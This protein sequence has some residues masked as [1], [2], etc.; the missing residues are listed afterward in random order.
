M[1]WNFASFTAPRRVEYLK[2]LSIPICTSTQEIKGRCQCEI[3][4]FGARKLFNYT[5]ILTPEAG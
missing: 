2:C 4:F 1:L 3:G 5:E